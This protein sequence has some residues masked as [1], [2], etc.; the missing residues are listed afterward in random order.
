MTLLEFSTICV[1]IYISVTHITVTNKPTNA[2]P[3]QEN[4]SY[5]MLGKRTA[6]KLHVTQST[7]LCSLFKTRIWLKLVYTAVRI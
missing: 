5:N 7:H 2:I 1:C 6:S 3:F 4:N